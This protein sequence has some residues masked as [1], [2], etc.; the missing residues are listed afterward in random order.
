MLCSPAPLPLLSAGAS[1]LIS[2]A[3]MVCPV[4]IG[5]ALSQTVP[6]V[7]AAVSGATATKLAFQKAAVKRVPVNNPVPS[8][9]WTG[10]SAI[11]GRK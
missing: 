7:V 5:A 8:R 6:A 2:A 3:N 11:K 10:Q 4:C 1:L 9:R